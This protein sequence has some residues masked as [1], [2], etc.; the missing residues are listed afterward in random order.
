MAALPV[1]V[2]GRGR[3]GQ[4]GDGRRSRSPARC[5]ASTGS[6]SRSRHA[7]LLRRAPPRQRHHHRRDGRHVPRRHRRLSGRPDV[8]PPAAGARDL[9]R[10]RRSR[11]C[12]AACSS[13]SLA[14][15]FAGL[16]Q[17]WLTQGDALLLGVAVAV[18]GPDRRP[19]RVADQARRRHQGRGHA[20]RRPRRRARPARRGHLHG[21]GRLLRLA[22]GDA[23][24]V[25]GPTVVR[26]VALSVPVAPSRTCSTACSRSSPVESARCPA[27]AGRT[28]DARRRASRCGGPR[29]GRRALASFAEFSGGWP[30]S[31]RERRLHDYEPDVISGRFV[32]RTEWAPRPAE[33]TDRHC[34]VGERRLRR[35]SHP[36]T[37]TCLE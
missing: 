3:R 18:L 13:R 2:P 1:A 34:A 32:I 23:L 6:G 21:R 15:F 8:R 16:Y 24:V 26:E 37:R 7:V 12:S 27:A 25:P 17:T 11:D 14:V 31:G 5:S 36:T 22:R 30:T 33:G 29:A 4:R 19:V 9:A 20:V 28:A 35:R 10:T